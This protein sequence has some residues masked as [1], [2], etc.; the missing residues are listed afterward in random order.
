[1]LPQSYLERL[2]VK[3]KAF[4]DARNALKLSC[5]LAP[6]VFTCAFILSKDVI[7]SII[8]AAIFTY[9]YLKVKAFSFLRKV[10]YESSLVDSYAAI[11]L[12]ELRLV[13]ST[14][15][16]L[17]QA[18]TFVSNGDYPLISKAFKRVLNLAQEGISLT[19]ALSK[20]AKEQTSETMRKGLWLLITGSRKH[21]LSERIW[22]LSALQSEARNRFTLYMKHTHNSLLVLIPLAFLLPP[23]MVL[24]L[25]IKRFTLLIL[26]LLIP[27]HLILLTL[28]IKL[29]SRRVAPP[30]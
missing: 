9:A 11:V 15:G 30:L 20:L 24:A 8:C 28:T 7:V 10:E 1:M 27:M 5:V 16:S 6:I 3:A 4:K 26:P 2:T 19:V 29:L 18:L 22:D 14:S 21:G 17:F 12:E 25:T 23:S 13:L